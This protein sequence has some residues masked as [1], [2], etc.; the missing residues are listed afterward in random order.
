MTLLQVCR[1]EVCRRDVPRLGDSAAQ[2]IS[3]ML[4]DTPS[5]REFALNMFHVE[6]PEAA[7]TF[8]GLNSESNH[9]SYLSLYDIMTHS[10]FDT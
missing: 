1:L 8:N 3:T 4:S 7:T 9:L 6:T 10:H 2:A 5:L